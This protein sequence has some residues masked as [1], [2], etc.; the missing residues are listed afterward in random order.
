MPNRRC[1]RVAVVTRL[2]IT[3]AMKV[4]EQQYEQL[5]RWYRKAKKQHCLKPSIEVRI[6]LML[7]AWIDCLDRWT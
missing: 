4:D 6:F 3:D 2:R 1:S 7:S 5:L